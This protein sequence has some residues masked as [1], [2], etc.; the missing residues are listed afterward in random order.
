[1]I[2]LTGA[3]ATFIGHW[4]R[5]SMPFEPSFRIVIVS[6]ATKITAGWK[7]KTRY[8]RVWRVVGEL[9]IETVDKATQT[10][11]GNERDDPPVIVY[12]KELR[13]RNLFDTVVV[14]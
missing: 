7:K 11:V 12:F 13:F 6:I 14:N 4:V 1:M 8:S 5:V 2:R 10:R 3:T 9:Q